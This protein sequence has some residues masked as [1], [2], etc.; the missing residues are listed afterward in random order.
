MAHIEY[1]PVF[2][3]LE[4]RPALVVGGGAVAL[5]KAL[6]LRKA[7]AE[8]TVLAPQ[9]CPALARHAAAG[10]VRH[11]A[12]PFSPE[13]L[14]GAVAAVAATDERDVNAAV[15]VAARE[16]RVPVNVVDDAALST[17]IFPAI[18]DRS[19][20][21]VAVSSAGHAPVLARRVREQ[22]EALLP[23]R[24][25]ALA[26]FLGARRGAVQRALRGLG[27][28]AFWEQLISGPLA[29]RVLNGEEQRAGREW[30]RALLAAQRAARRGAARPQGEVYLIGAGPG[31]PDLLTLRALQLL[32][33]ADV[34]LYDRLV[35]EAVLERARRDARRIFVGKEAGEPHLQAHIN[36]LLV[37]LAGEG[38]RV[39][40]LKVG[41]PFVFGRGGEELEALA[42][43]G[44]PCTVVPGITAA[45]GAA[46]S[47][48]IPLTHRR[49]ASSVTF[50]NGHTSGEALPDWRFLARPEHTV[51]FYMGVAQLA[52]VVAQL[53]A[54]GASAAHPVAVIERA[55]LPGQRILRATLGTITALA[56]AQRIQAP[57]LLITGD[58]AAFEADGCAAVVAGPGSTGLGVTGLGVTG[59]GAPGA[60]PVR[61]ASAGVV[62]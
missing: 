22:I 29:T 48:A 32:Q 60:P 45:L 44:I 47:A 59:L 41:D 38:K 55:T 37:R 10:E 30:S 33:Q 14:A 28:R 26:R 52:H 3:R 36:A 53:R 25:G 31:D 5:R 19:P 8:V 18:V 4:G 46:A 40:R 49:L 17:F 61:P 58:V 11:L 16:R 50:V 9:L 15:A 54:A 35:S 24:L 13:Q 43:R 1:L 12:A 20:L 21:L 51:V 27:R 6:W 7:G 2:L 62:A 23:S 57:A 56:A 42:T 39:A 34:I